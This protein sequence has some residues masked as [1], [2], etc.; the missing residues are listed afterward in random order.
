MNPED[1][2]KLDQLITDASDIISCTNDS[3]ILPLL[4]DGILQHFIEAIV[5]PKLNRNQNI[6]DYLLE[7]KRRLQLLALI[8]LSIQHNYSIKG[9]V[10]SQDVFVSPNEYQWFDDGVMFLQGKERFA[11]LIGLYQGGRVK[12]GIAKRDIRG[13]DQVGPDA[14]EFVDIDDMAERSRQPRVP[15][16][17]VQLDDRI[18]QLEQMLARHENKEAEYQQYFTDNAWIFGAQYKQ[19]DSHLNLDD[20]RIP[21]F[22]GVRVKDSARDI[23]EIKPPY[24]PL[25]TSTGSFRAEFHNA[26]NKAERYLDFAHTEA[27]YLYRQKGLH[28]DNPKCF[29]VAGV[30]LTDPLLKEIRRK[31][32][33]NPLI[34]ILTYNDVL[35][36]ARSTACLVKSL[37]G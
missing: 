35:A 16:D 15:K 27:D 29:L 13:G 36:M 9:K 28:F 2:Q 34:T 31:E 7:N 21:D 23:I 19:I 22:T 6:Y 1:K 11:G 5:K 14:L 20:E 4:G 10:E 33:M 3:D 18:C 24:L 25:F 8:R 32:R 17:L 12:F 37:K 30:D 26:W